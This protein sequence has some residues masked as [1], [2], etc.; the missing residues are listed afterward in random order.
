[1]HTVQEI[2]TWPYSRIRAEIREQRS[3]IRETRRSAGGFDL[4]NANEYLSRLYQALD[5]KNG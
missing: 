2:V 3:W 1:M 5:I 4:S